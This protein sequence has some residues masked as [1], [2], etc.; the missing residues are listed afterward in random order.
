MNFDLLEDISL[1]LQA[2]AVEAQNLPRTAVQSLGAFLE[3]AHIFPDYTQETA[4]SSWLDR[5]QFRR[6]PNREQPWFFEDGP[7]F[8]VCSHDSHQRKRYRLD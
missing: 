6:F 8:A 7:Q 1:A 5:R 2:G 4:I 3:L